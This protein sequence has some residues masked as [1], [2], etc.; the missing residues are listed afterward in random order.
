MTF[1]L[2]VKFRVDSFVV[3]AQHFTDGLSSSATIISDE[4]LVDVCAIPPL[5]AGR[6]FSLLISRA[7]FRKRTTVAVRGEQSGVE[8]EGIRETS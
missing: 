8:P 2:D 4:K 5:F 6:H 1:A 7:S 3:S